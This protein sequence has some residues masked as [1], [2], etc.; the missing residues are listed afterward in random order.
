MRW[1]SSFT[2]PRALAKAMD[3]F[4]DVRREFYE[5]GSL[6]LTFKVQDPDSWWFWSTLLSFGEDIE[7]IEPAGLRTLMQSKLEKSRV[8]AKV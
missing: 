2:Y 6:R 4:Y 8:Y 1:K 5:D 7:I 3:Q